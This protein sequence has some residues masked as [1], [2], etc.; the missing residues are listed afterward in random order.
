MKTI[1]TSTALILALSLSASAGGLVL[2]EE[3]Y[4]PESTRGGMS[5]KDAVPFLIGGAVLLCIALCGDNDPAP[6]PVVICNKG[7]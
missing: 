6:A 4:E 1:L 5:L 2:P 3:D 7:C